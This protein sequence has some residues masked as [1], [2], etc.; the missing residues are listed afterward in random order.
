[1]LAYDVI[2]ILTEDNQL[3]LEHGNQNRKSNKHEQQVCNDSV[4]LTRP[5]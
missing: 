5:Q 1:M 2:D 3:N 4:S